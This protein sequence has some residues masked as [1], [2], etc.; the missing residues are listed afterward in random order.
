MCIVCTVWSSALFFLHICLYSS[1]I[2]PPFLS[3]RIEF[4][5]LYYMERF[6]YVRLKKIY[7]DDWYQ[8]ALTHQTRTKKKQNLIYYINKNCG[9]FFVLS[10]RKK[11]RAYKHII[12]ISK[13]V[14][15]PFDNLCGEYTNIERGRRGDGSKEKNDNGQKCY[16]NNILTFYM[17]V[18]ASEQTSEC[19]FLCVSILYLPLLFEFDNTRKEWKWKKNT[20]N[21]NNTEELNSKNRF[22]GTEVRSAC[23]AI[24][25]GNRFQV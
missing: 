10:S 1:Y 18:R 12:C 15:K 2:L 11:R 6:C 22:K 5:T 21:N 17:N 8:W 9:S 24:I 3:N 19:V 20:T 7:H 13:R 25:Y 4:F 14:T 16:R 23:Y